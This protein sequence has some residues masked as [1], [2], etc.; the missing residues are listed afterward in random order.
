[1]RT[2]NLIGR[3]LLLL[4][5]AAALSWG[6]NSDKPDTDT[7]AVDTLSIEKQLERQI[8][9]VMERLKYDDKSAM[10]ENEFEYLHEELTFDEY[11]QTRGVSQAAADSLSHVEVTSV[12][13]FKDSAIARV[14]VHFKGF[15]GR[16]S[17]VN[18]TITLYYHDGR[19]IKPTMSTWSRQ[20]SFDSL[21]Q[22][23]I[24]QAEREAGQ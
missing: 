18:D 14:V 3:L 10:W 5:I 21:R 11:L 22:A 4:V 15:S 16:E 23:A 8:N 24:D 19:W 12:Q 1:M 9:L 6:C 20:M 7:A 13:E 2:S 17:A